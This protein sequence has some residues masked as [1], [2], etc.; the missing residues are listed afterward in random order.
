MRRNILVLINARGGRTIARRVRRVARSLLSR[1]EIP[2]EIVVT[3][4]VR[5]LRRLA[6]TAKRRGFTEIAAAGGDGTVGVI[7][8]ELRDDPLPISIIPQGTGNI[9]AKHLGV[10]LSIRPA[11]KALI[12]SDRTVTLDAI[13]RPDGMSVLNLSIGLS[14]LT[15][16]DVDTRI[17]RVFGTATYFAGVLLYLLRRNPAWF[18]IVV[19]GSE[20][21]VRGRE[22]LVSNAGFRR[23]AI[24]TFFAD[25]VPNDGVLECSIFIAGGLR[26]AFAVVADVLQGA[27][28]RAD[29][30]MVRFP[31]RESIRIESSPPLPIQAD[32]DKVGFGTANATIR[33]NALIVRAPAV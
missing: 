28:K 27:P 26:G 1:A 11:L 12:A 5:T 2:H 9:L 31:V 18:R 14:S 22:V 33:R 6:A 20:H 32:G 13:E 16:A 23:T 10:P 4:S 15:M 25:S 17:K 24:E 8:A 21:R 30:Y 3:R 7:A 19:D 29:R